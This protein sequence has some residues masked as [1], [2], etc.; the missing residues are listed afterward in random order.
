MSSLQTGPDGVSSPTRMMRSELGPAV[1]R[2]LIAAACA[3]K[4]FVDRA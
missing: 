4:A 1:M 2:P 3:H